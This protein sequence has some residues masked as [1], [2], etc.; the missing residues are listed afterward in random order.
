MKALVFEP[1]GALRVRRARFARRS[2]LPVG[3]ACMVAVSMREKLAALL[4]ASVS[5]RL[6]EPAVPSTQAWLTIARDALI[7]RARG[8]AA[9]AA[10]VFRAPD[11]SA[12]AAAAFGEAPPERTAAR[13]LSALERDVLD[14]VAGAIAP[15]LQSVCGTRDREALE[16]LPTLTA[17]ATYF[18]VLLEQPFDARIGIALSRDPLPEAHGRLTLDDLAGVPLQPAVRMD[19]ASLHARRVASLVPGD[20]LPMAPGAPTARLTV[21]DQTI[22]HGTCG[23]RGGRFA[24]AVGAWA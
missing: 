11:A 20:L 6:L 5:V 16:C 12:I 2:Y 18:E 7:Y 10:I 8:V 9:D 19:V 4:G 17:F 3:A 13:E 23:V 15:S 1:S 22:A 14:R 24:F 21:A